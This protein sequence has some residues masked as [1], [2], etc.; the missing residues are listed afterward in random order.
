MN[1]TDVFLE[2]S[3]TKNE[4]QLLYRLF[5]LCEVPPALDK[6]SKLILDTL[7]AN[8]SVGEAELFFN[9]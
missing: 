2:Y 6:F 3:F 1:D 7:Y 4:L 8:M 5:C 9:E